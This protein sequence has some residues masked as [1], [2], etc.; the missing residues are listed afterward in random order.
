MS[1]T[2]EILPDSGIQTLDI[3]DTS[4]KLDGFVIPVGT[5]CEL[6]TGDSLDQIRA[7]LDQIRGEMSGEII[8]VLAGNCRIPI[9][10]A[11]TEG[12]N[13]G[14]VSIAD[15]KIQAKGIIAV[16]PSENGYSRYNLLQGQA[17]Y[18][19]VK[20]VCEVYPDTDIRVMG[21][22]LKPTGNSGETQFSMKADSIPVNRL[23]KVY[24]I[25]GSGD[26]YAADGQ[27][28]IG[29]LIEEGGVSIDETGNIVT[30]IG[31]NEM[32]LEDVFGLE[33][34]KEEPIAGEDLRSEA[35][36]PVGC[37][38]SP[39]S[40]NKVSPSDALM[41]LVAIVGARLAAIIKNTIN[42]TLGK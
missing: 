42:T 40:L 5:T 10:P 37:N 12:C 39:V 16:T 19:A 24:M 26:V 6:Y 36:V 18:D 20:G 38:S 21:F 9:P 30:N 29:R 8:R 31:K 15:S 2:N 7:Q 23:A 35:K 41:V 14:P 22:Q 11:I 28:L 33:N 25:S 4:E 32:P 17:V 1:D 34:I 13:P 27:E 3:R